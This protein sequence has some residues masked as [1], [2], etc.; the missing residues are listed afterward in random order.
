[1]EPRRGPDSAVVVTLTFPALSGFV[2]RSGT[3]SLSGDALLCTLPFKL[4]VGASS[5]V[6]E[7]QPAYEEFVCFVIFQGISL[8]KIKLHVSFLG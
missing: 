8:G 5:P 4:A 2:P 3:Q 1:M 6:Q 7:G